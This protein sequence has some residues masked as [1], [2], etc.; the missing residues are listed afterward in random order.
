MTLNDK[1]VSEIYNITSTIDD[2][3]AEIKSDI[4]KID[5]VILF[6]N[7]RVKEFSEIIDRVES[8]QR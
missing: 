1:I 7:I 4:K 3:F 6:T 2:R 5:S 8:Y